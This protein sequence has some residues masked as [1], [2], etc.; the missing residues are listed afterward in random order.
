MNGQQMNAQMQQANGQMQQ[1]PMNAQLE[2]VN[3]QMMTGQQMNGQMEQVNGQQMGGQGVQP[4]SPLANDPN[5]PMRQST[6]Y[7]STAGP[8]YVSGQG[9][10]P[11]G[12]IMELYSP[13]RQPSER[14]SVVGQQ[15][16][17]YQ[18][19]QA[20]G[21]PIYQQM[22]PQLYNQTQMYGPMNPQVYGQINGQ[23]VYAQPMMMQAMPSNGTDISRTQSVVYVPVIAN[24]QDRNSFLIQSSLNRDVNRISDR[25]SLVSQQSSELLRYTT[26]QPS[27]SYQDLQRPNTSYYP[28]GPN[29]PDAT[30]FVAGEGEMLHR[31]DVK[32]ENQ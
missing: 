30:D 4:M 19:G 23:T 10:S 3:G 15:S 22:N 21:I 16:Q 17:I 25:Q 26:N 18:N 11:G 5:L 29:F 13:A 14:G 7:Y 6:Q 28:T 27:V 8:Q 20:P 31:D 1:P 24:P 32:F 12:Q 9:V 2:M